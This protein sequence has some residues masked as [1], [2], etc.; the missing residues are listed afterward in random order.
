MI[1]LRT[2]RLLRFILHTYQC[3]R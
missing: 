3:Y 1:V 2:I